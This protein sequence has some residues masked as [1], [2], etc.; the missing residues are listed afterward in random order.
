MEKA[1]P[2]TSRSSNVL[3]VG[4]TS[5]IGGIE[6]LFRGIVRSVDRDILHFD[7]LCNEPVMAFEE[8]LEGLGCRVYHITARRQSR[9]RFYREL[10]AFFEAHATEYDVVWENENSAANIDYLVYAKRYG[11]PKR[12]MHCHNAQNGEGLIR[13]VFH[14]VNRPNLRDVATDFWTVSDES[15][16][17]FF[18]KGYRKLPGYHVFNNAIEVRPFAYSA[19]TRAEAR[20]SLGIPEDAIVLLNTGRLVRQK[21]QGV[22]LSTAAELIREGKNVI[23]LIAGRGELHDELLEQSRE[24]GIE[25]EVKLLGMVPDASGLY[26]AADVFFLPSLFEGLSISLMEAQANGVPIVTSSAIVGRSL[27]NDNIVQVDVAETSPV[28]WARAVSEAIEM[29]R[30]AVSKI[31]GSEFDIATQAQTIQELLTATSKIKNGTA[32]SRWYYAAERDPEEYLLTNAGGKAREDIARILSGK[33]L[34]EL[35]VPV[36]KGRDQMSGAAKVAAHLQ[37]RDNWVRATRELD[38]GDTLV[39]QFPPIGHTVFIGGV[40]RTLHGRGVRIVLLVHDLDGLRSIFGNPGRA[41]QLRLGIE[42]TAALQTAD[43]VIVH[44]GTMV[45]VVASRYGVDRR[46]LMPL[47]IFD[48]L[49]DDENI[50]RFVERDKGAPVVVAGNLSPV[51]SSYLKELPSD[52]DFELYG[53]GYEDK[54]LRNV[55]YKGVVPAEELPF[56]MDGAFGLVWDGDSAST[57]SGVTGQYLKLNNPHKASL[58][59]ASGMPVVIWDQAALAPFVTDHGCGIAIGSLDELHRRLESLSCDQYDK[60]LSASRR[61]GEGLRRGTHTTQALETARLSLDGRGRTWGYSGGSGSEERETVSV[62]TPFFRGNEYLPRLSEC[63]SEAARKAEGL[64]VEWVIVNDS[65][66]CDVLLPPMPDSVAL[67]VIQHQSNKGIHASRVDGLKPCHGDAVLFLDQDD[68]ILPDF[69]KDAYGALQASR[70]AAVVCN[71]WRENPDGTRDAIYSR[72][73][74][75]RKVNDLDYYLKVTNPIQSPGQCLIRRRDIPKGYLRHVLQHNGSDDLLLWIEMLAEGKRL[76]C[77]D[78][79]LYVHKD[80]GR[81]VSASMEVLKGSSLEAMDALEASGALSRRQLSELRRSIDYSVMTGTEKRLA[82][83]LYPDLVLKRIE[84]KL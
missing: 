8:E 42:E 27:L 47:G 40:L 12:I 65:P 35:V 13:G 67:K 69:L 77:L 44:N 34:Q 53:S 7:F 68:E 5:N 78:E 71:G 61:V 41:A 48:Y 76:A 29:G 74:D 56:S 57:C 63:L 6:T 75:W 83:V 31:E 38:L 16:E 17:W 39:V 28:V 73:R 30:T 24:L 51:K 54:G 22:I 52:V 79:H 60:M 23:V 10:R 58:Y 64:V 43:Q 4:M 50:E 19:N 21:N 15:S 62:I 2:A 32:W 70:A 26:S 45:D 14:A 33:G 66:D 82:A 37:S 36:V 11:I 80:T 46:K 1:Q 81:N 25:N 9:S 3:V 55:H 49:V 20:A 18:G 59:L 84:Y 72:D